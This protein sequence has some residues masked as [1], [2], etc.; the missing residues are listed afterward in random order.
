MVVPGAKHGMGRWRY[1]N[2]AT[3][4]RISTVVIGGYALNILAIVASFA[5]GQVR[6]AIL[7]TLPL[8]ISPVAALFVYWTGPRSGWRGAWLI[9]LPVR[10]EDLLPRMEAA[11]RTGGFGVRRDEPSQKP[12]WLRNS[13]VVLDLAGG[14]RVWLMPG[15]PGS[16]AGL[17]P[18][19]QPL[20]TVVVEGGTALET[21]ELERLRDVLS[22]LDE[23]LKAG[24]P[25]DRR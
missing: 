24:P 20:T 23:F 2:P 16:K 4:K 15:V 13:R 3:A 6:L 22:R 19:L 12:A 10:L 8:I 18:R 14:L 1:N 9:R 11:L 21:A 17:D 25:A 7:L 5:L